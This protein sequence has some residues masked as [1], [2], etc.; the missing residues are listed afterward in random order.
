MR[1]AKALITAALIAGMALSSLVASAAHGNRITPTLH[2]IEVMHKGKMITI[3]R[4]GDKNATIPKAYA[5]TGRHCPPFCIQ[6]I[7]VAQGVETLGELEVLGYLQRMSDGDR[8]VMVIDS[9]TPDWMRHGTIPGSV[10]IPWDKINVDVEGTFEIE[11]EAE[12]L[13]DILQNRF[14]AQ[15]VGGKWDFRNAKTLVL[16]CN[17]I[18]CPQSAINIK[19]LL[20]LGY[21]AYKLKWYRGGMQDWVSVGLTTVNN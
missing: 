7:H 13:H 11:T 18:W 10:N 1:T 19:T 4:T 5:K 8:K 9:R 12:T 3:E 14:G 17:G 6:P 16:F 15:L 2:S 21:P 20:K